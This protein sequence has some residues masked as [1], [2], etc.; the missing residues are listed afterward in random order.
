MGTE[1]VCM[2]ACMHGWH[3]M[4]PR[5]TEYRVSMDGCMHGWHL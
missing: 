4:I 2:D 5:I 1:L 3:I